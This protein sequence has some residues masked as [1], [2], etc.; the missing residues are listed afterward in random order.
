MSVST[1]LAGLYLSC[2]DT[3][4]AAYLFAHARAGCEVARIHLVQY[5]ADHNSR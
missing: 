1:D 4:Y 3:P 5:A 2:P